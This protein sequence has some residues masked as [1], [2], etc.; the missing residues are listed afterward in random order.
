MCYVFVFLLAD[1]NL[2]STDIK[3]FYAYCIGI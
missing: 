3:Y 1:V 2:S